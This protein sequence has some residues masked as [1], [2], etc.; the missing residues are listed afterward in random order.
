MKKLLTAYF[1]LLSIGIHAQGVNDKDLKPLDNNHQ[2]ADIKNTKAG[3]Y[4]LATK[5]NIVYAG[6]TKAAK[7]N[8][9]KSRKFKNLKGVNKGYYVIANVFKDKDNLAKNI[10][11]LV[12]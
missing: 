5:D 3:D 4:S 12:K 6:S 11:K 7:R 8:N 10:N 1:F 9:I 2:S